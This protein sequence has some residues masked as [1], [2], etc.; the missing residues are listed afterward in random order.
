MSTTH[1]ITPGTF[2]EQIGDAFAVIHQNMKTGETT[3]LCRFGSDEARE[4]YHFLVETLGESD[5]FED[6]DFEDNED[7][8]DEEEA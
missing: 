3:E 4:L 6:T 7:E 2:I 1:T 5:V 8:S